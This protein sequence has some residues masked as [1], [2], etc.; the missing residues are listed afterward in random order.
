MI[1]FILVNYN[2]CKKTAHCVTSIAQRCPSEEFEVIIV[3]NASNDGSKEF[4]EAY[5]D[6]RVKYIFNELN[7]G[8]G[9][10]C[11]IGA[12]SARGKYL[13]FLNSDA[14]LKS[15]ISEELIKNIFSNTPN[16]GII[17]PSVKFPSGQ[18]QVNV[19]KFSVPFDVLARTLRLGQRYR[20]SDVLRWLVKVSPIRPTSVK[21]YL[22]HLDGTSEKPSFHDWASGCALI[23]PEDVYAKVN[24]FDEGYFLYSE[25]E[26]LCERI[27]A[28]GYK[29]ML[30]PTIEI[31][32]EMGASAS[33]DSEFIM[34]CKFNSWVRLFGKRGRADLVSAKYYILLS[35]FISLFSKKGRFILAWMWKNKL[36]GS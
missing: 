2:T 27:G 31:F 18:R 15:A 19:G 36:H 22:G 12:K 14:W 3:D 8:F 6:N 5:Q 20:Q 9:A 21:D 11:N 28:L 30:C 29:I 26:D 34:D 13:F 32:H 7:I 16:L 35:A 23:I 33:N 17:A 1:S 24:G 4:F 10:A 25:D